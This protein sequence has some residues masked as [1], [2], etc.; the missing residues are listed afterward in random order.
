MMNIVFVNRPNPLTEKKIQHYLNQICLFFK[1]HRVRQQKKL[2]QCQEISCVFLNRR[3]MKKINNQFRQK[4]KPTDVLSFQSE[5]PDSLGELLFCVSVLKTQAKQQKHHLEH[6]FLYMLIHGVLHL[7]GYDH[8]LSKEEHQKMFRLQ[9]RCF[10]F[11]LTE[12]QK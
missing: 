3:E 7:L 12:M 2:Q 4:N 10:S 6:E 5:D 9:D 8:E 11:I 1:T